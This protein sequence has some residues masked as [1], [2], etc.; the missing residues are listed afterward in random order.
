M[1][2]RNFT[3][4]I[5]HAGRCFLTDTRANLGIPFAILAPMLIAFV[6]AAIDL[7]RANSIRTDMQ[8][9]LDSASLMLSKTASTLTAAQ[10]TSTGASYFN[11]MFTRKDVSGTAVASTYTKT[12]G[13]QIVMTA[14]TKMSTTFLSILGWSTLDLGVTSTA[15]WGSQRLRVALALDVTGSM[16][17]DGKLPALKTAAKNLLTQLQ[18]AAVNDGDV[19]VSI[20]PFSKDVNIGTSNSGQSYIDWTSW[21]ADITNAS[22]SKSG[23]SSQLLCILGGG[24]WSTNNKSKWNGCVADR[25]GP[26]APD[27]NNYDQ[28]ISAPTGN[29]A[30][31]YP[32]EQYSYC[33]V[34]MMGLSYNWTALG[35]L[36][37][38]MTAQ[39]STNQ[40]IGLVW[41]WQ[42]LVGGG[43][44]TMPAKDSNYTYNDVIILMSDG[45]NTQDRWYGNG[46]TPSTSVDY[47]MYRSNGT[48]TCVN[49]KAAGIMIYTIQVN[50]GGDPTSALLKSCA[51]STDK[52]V[53]LTSASQLIT[54]FASIGT[55]LTKL[56]ISN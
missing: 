16:A 20:I 38:S 22:C 44:L 32:A 6:G 24:T 21:N 46:S 25:G 31:M 5:R 35:S 41:A 53:E 50:T 15:K 27:P 2:R 4:D 18:G 42:S 3:V 19:Y 55:A 13:S 51:T 47:R 36:I 43:P 34:A 28:T 17:D 23:Y 48:G 1:P 37:D 49:A 56:R 11:A 10:I 9:S 8:V 54:A 29:T 52:F 12:T 40:P 39:G 26:I 33:P 45:L 30:S 14:T 7:S